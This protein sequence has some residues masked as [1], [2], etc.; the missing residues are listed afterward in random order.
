MQFTAKIAKTLVMATAVLM[1]TVPVMAGNGHGPGNGT[2]T[3]DGPQD[4]KVTDREQETVRL[5]RS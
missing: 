4:G 3:G 1:L 5:W 2:G